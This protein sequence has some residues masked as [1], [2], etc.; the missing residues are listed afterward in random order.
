MTRH[1]T[2]AADFAGFVFVAFTI[3]VVL[4]I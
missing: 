3:A 4:C 2:P 1:D